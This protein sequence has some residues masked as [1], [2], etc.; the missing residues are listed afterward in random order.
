M[1]KKKVVKKPGTKPTKNPKRKSAT[2]WAPAKPK[3]TK[4]I[5]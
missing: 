3:P 4:T 1:A 2:T 5:Y